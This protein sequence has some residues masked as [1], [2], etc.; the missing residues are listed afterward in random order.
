MSDTVFT[1]RISRLSTVEFKYSDL[2]VERFEINAGFNGTVKHIKRLV[3]QGVFSSGFKIAV[4]EKDGEDV[5]VLYIEDWRPQCFPEEVLDGTRE[6][7]KQVRQEKKQERLSQLE[8][9]TGYDRSWDVIIDEYDITDGGGE[10][11]QTQF[12]AINEPN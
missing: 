5:G 12:F 2:E 7:Q 11:G 4:F 9:M 10:F 6:D 3:R 1:S 8:E